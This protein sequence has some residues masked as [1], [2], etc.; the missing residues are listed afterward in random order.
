MYNKGAAAAQAGQKGLLASLAGPLD[1]FVKSPSVIRKVDA[2]AKFHPWAHVGQPF[3]P[4]RGGEWTGPAV[5]IGVLSLGGTSLL[6]VLKFLEDRRKPI[7]AWFDKIAGKT[8]VEPS[9]VKAEPKRTWPDII[10]G[11]IGSLALVYSVLGIF[12]P[13]FIDNV[14]NWIGDGAT[15][16]IKKPVVTPTATTKI[17]IGSAQYWARLAVFDLFFTAVTATATYAFSKAA[18]A[19]KGED[20]NKRHKE[21]KGFAGLHFGNF[22]HKAVAEERPDPSVDED[23]LNRWQNALNRE[24]K[25]EIASASPKRLAGEQPA[26]WSERSNKDNGTPNITVH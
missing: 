17:P 6:P 12:G 10:K 26:N 18:A 20:N 15:R 19:A 24:G 5:L 1:R 14:Q 16:L 11:R 9:Q 7:S 22:G 2:V 23:T 13:V 8:P 3:G 21:H 4:S 25:S